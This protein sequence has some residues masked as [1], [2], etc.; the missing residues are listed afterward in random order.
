MKTLVFLLLIIISSSIAHSQI[1]T[2]DFNGLAGNEA[3]ANSNSNDANITASVISRG[4]GL[5]ASN[6]GNRFNATSWALTSIA[7]AVTGND[8]MEFTITPTGGCNFSITSIDV[9]LQRSGTGP[10][11][12]A[13]RSSADGFTANLDTE[14]AIVDNTSTQNFTFTFSQTNI[15]V[16]TTYRL[17]MF[18]ES[19]GGSGGFGDGAGNDI[20]VNG[21]TSC[22]APNTIT[23]GAIAT[24]P[25]NIDCTNS[26]TDAGTI[27]FTSSGTFNAGNIYTAQLSDASGSF[28]SPTTI[29]TLA[30]TANSGSINITIP[31]SLTTG[32]GYLIRIISDNPN[33]TGTSS[34]AF[35]I[36]QTNPCV[37]NSITTGA[38]TGAPFSVDC[39]GTD[40]TGSIAFTSAGVYTAGNIYSAELSDAT[41][42]FASPIV[43]GTLASTANSGSISITIPATMAIGAGYLI[44]ITSDSPVTTGSSSASFTITQIG[45]CGPTLPSTEGLIINEWSN[46]PSGNQE[47][48]EF[49]VAGQCGTTVDIRGYI[50]DDN[51]GTFT[52]PAS[53]SGTASGIAPGHFRFSNSAQWGAIPVGSLIVIY[54]NDDP[55]PDLPADDP[56]DANNDS[57]YVVPHDNALFERCLSFPTSSSPDS[58]YIPC[59][60]AT[61]PL[62]GW[63]ALSLRNSGDAIQ[64]R[65]PDGSYYHGVSYGGS[66]ISGGPHNLKQFTGSGSGMMG[67][68][69][70]GDFFDVSNWSSG[71]VAGNQTPGLPNNAT[72]YAWLVAMRDPSAAT[73][74]IVV[75]PVE[76]TGFNGTKKEGSNFLYWS[77]ES[78]RNSLNF[79]VQ[80]SNDGKNWE[81]I[82]TTLAAGFSQQDIDYSLYDFDFPA[83]VNYY[84]LKQ[85]D[86]DGASSIH[87]KV[88]ALDNRVF[89]EPIVVKIVNILG[90]EIRPEDKGVQIHIYSDGTSEK[91]FKH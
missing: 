61:A 55:N 46:G 33:T 63:G 86:R 16:A 29:G 43:I 17:Y 1:L 14:Y 48:Y 52:T 24:A 20:I 27:A 9:Q 40:D 72:N 38:I 81:T 42:S 65:F 28:A 90:Q 47:Y 35:T 79:E 18:A 8:Y 4:A 56:T 7:N 84:R 30:S 75:L 45:T 78:E 49:V 87:P 51:N 2:F 74:P 22:A 60:Y 91:I 5:T 68:F 73:C 82:G 76:I 36:T 69:N 37:P 77:T 26:I 6:N 3:T 50:L 19:T 88:V 13:L 59:T 85:N 12:I 64:V 89:D 31:S 70:T 23:T 67:W 21:S 66:E 57:L 25:F 80:R 11:G 34:T 71:A 83:Q 39:A 53:Y 10:R 15:T 62:G 32:A 44:R 54:N 41:G 58:V